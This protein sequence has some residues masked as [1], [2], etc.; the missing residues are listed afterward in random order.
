MHEQMQNSILGCK[1]AFNF[2]KIEEAKCVCM[3]IFTYMFMLYIIYIL[4]IYIYVYKYKHNVY[5]DV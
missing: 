3:F 4:Y 5:K 1:P 2:Y